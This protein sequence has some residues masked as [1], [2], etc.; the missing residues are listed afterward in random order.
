MRMTGALLLAN[1]MVSYN[2][3]V[4]AVFAIVMVGVLVGAL[5]ECIW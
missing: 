4:F 2:I 3:M 5:D 1:S